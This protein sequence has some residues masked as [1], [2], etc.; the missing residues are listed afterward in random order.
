MQVQRLLSADQFAD[1]HDLVWPVATVRR[2]STTGQ[3]PSIPS[4]APA[5]FMG[6]SWG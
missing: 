3:R 4:H 5:W 2:M 6:W 1:V